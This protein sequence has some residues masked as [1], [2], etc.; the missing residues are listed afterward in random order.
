MQRNNNMSVIRRVD[1]EQQGDLVSVESDDAIRTLTSDEEGSEVSCKCKPGGPLGK[2]S[3]ITGISQVYKMSKKRF[4][5]EKSVESLELISE[6]IVGR[7]HLVV[8]EMGRS[9]SSLE[10]IRQQI[11]QREE[12]SQKRYGKDKNG[13]KR[14][15]VKKKEGKLSTKYED[16]KRKI[17][18]LQEEKKYLNKAKGY[19]GELNLPQNCMTKI[20]QKYEAVQ[21]LKAELKDLTIKY[22]KCR[23]RNQGLENEL[24]ENTNKCEN[25]ERKIQ[26]LQVKNNQWE[27]K[28]ELYQT[29]LLKLKREVCELTTLAVSFNTNIQEK[30]ERNLH[31][32]ENLKNYEIK[33]K[34]LKELKERMAMENENKVQQ[35]EEK[36]KE[37][38]IKYETC[39][40]KNQQLEKQI[41]ERAW[42]CQDSKKTIQKLE[43]EKKNW[44]RQG[45]SDGREI[46]HQEGDCNTPA[47]ANEDFEREV[48]VI[49]GD[50]ENKAVTDEEANQ[51]LSQRELNCEEKVSQMEKEKTTLAMRNECNETM[52]QLLKEE[53]RKMAKKEEHIE[54]RLDLLEMQNTNLKNICKKLLKSTNKNRSLWS[55]MTKGNKKEENQRKETKV[56]VKPDKKLKEEKEKKEGGLMNWLHG[57]WI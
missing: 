46:Q 31:L 28:N 43:T 55:L 19:E 52:I 18:Q 54:M 53:M 17:H 11:Q 41:N 45:G 14:I 26:E 25:L 13:G 22:K 9:S 51:N 15:H 7:D 42:K 4:R 30:H 10:D 44:S 38:A 35:L 34:E 32:A 8:R 3:L 23:T 33:F 12:H 39:E 16:F 5:Q 6:A 48:Q 2:T 40:E 24:R 56:K 21:Y 27:R 57:L 29:E 49:K 20:K 50:N 1:L 36:L 47:P 37:W